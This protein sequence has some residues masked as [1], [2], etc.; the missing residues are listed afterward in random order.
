MV[1]SHPPALAAA[2]LF[3]AILTWSRPGWGIT[4]LLAVLP[5]FAHHPA[6][7]LAHSLIALTAAVQFGYVLRVWP[8]ATAAWRAIAR[9]PLLLLAALF[10]A[11]A[12]LS[13]SS[14]PLSGM[15]HEY[16]AA[17]GTGPRV[18]WP[19]AVETWMQLGEARREFPV[20][21]ALLT[22]QGFV[23]AL[24][25]WR[26]T[27]ASSAAAVRLS[28][29]ITLGLLAF[30]GLGWLEA[31]GLVDLQALR[32]TTM[33]DV[34]PGT[35]QSMAGNPGW[36]SEYIVYA[37]PYALVLL[38]RPWRPGWRVVSLMGVTTLATLALFV[39]LQRGGWVSGAVVALYMA[40]VAPLLLSSSVG[41]SVSP[42]RQLWRGI[43]AVAVVSAL[44][45]GGFSMWLT[46]AR[47]GDT[48]IDAGT[49]VT[50]LKSI[51][52]GDRLPY[53][54]VSWKMALL[55]PVLGGGHESFAY[56]YDLHFQQPDGLYHPMPPLVQ[57]ASAHNVFLQ[58][59]TG[60]GA[61]GLAL[62]TGLL[63]VAALSVI[64]GIR[65]PDPDQARAGVVL[66]GGGSLLGI[67]CYG[68]VQEVFYIHTLRLLFFAGVGM[69]AG[70]TAG[71]T[72]WPRRT[73]P[74]LWL[75][76]GV[77]F[78][79]HLGYEYLWPGPERLLRA[80]TVTGLHGEERGPD[81]GP[82]RWSTEWSTWPVPAGV[83]AYSLQVRSLAPFPQRVEVKACGGVGT[84]VALSDHN[85]HAVDGLVD[86]CPGGGHLQLRV[87][88]SW[89]PPG[90]RRLLGVMT[91]GVRLR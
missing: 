81:N 72:A 8:S 39:S 70:A 86:G 57:G 41:T 22:L 15:W 64:R 62:L 43:G 82:F 89:R 33:V 78:T 14:L 58:T 2:A 21:S 34:R 5:L 59:L 63:G 52:D 9:Q 79:V 56:L 88:P 46:K 37:L 80:G 40:A 47:A 65:M 7:P 6:T 77:A 16:R 26:E 31:F 60:T 51:A 4:L 50:R 83:T 85:W 61:I 49:Y 17:L 74:M 53:L 29:A 87:S 35:P 27:K 66:A 13:L 10:V 68:L 20:T 55:H 48:T 36:F 38:A 11:A 1:P 28:A 71:Q 18:D 91:A 67:A 19:R 54:A 76:L 23:L 25:V 3:V 84:R 44:V 30:I 90:D 24:M 42:R 73:G 75:T 12:F 45:A 32:G 69:L